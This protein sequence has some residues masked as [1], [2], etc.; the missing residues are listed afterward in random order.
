[1]FELILVSTRENEL[2]RNLRTFADEEI[3]AVVQQ[4]LSLGEGESDPVAILGNHTYFVTTDL[5][6]KPFLFVN[7]RTRHCIPFT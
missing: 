4:Q 1:M 7:I 6:M 3:A 2:T 5:A